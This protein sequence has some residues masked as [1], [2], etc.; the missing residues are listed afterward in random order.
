MEPSPCT[1]C[2]KIGKDGWVGG[3][4]GCSDGCEDDK[5]GGVTGRGIG[6][7]ALS[8][9]AWAVPRC[10]SNSTSSGTAPTA[11]RDGIAIRK[12]ACR[13]SGAG[14]EVLASLTGES[15]GTGLLLP[16]VLLCGAGGVDTRLGALCT[17]PVVKLERLL[18]KRVDPAKRL[19]KELDAFGTD[20]KTSG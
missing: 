1:Y 13:V 7:E 5:T 18:W 17:F 3:S 12:A 19:I 16:S 11:C 9:S 8:H 2:G 14:G 20:V 10:N 4:V 6:Q 15:A